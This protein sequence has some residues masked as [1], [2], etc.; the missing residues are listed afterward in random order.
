MSSDAD[1]PRPP[2]ARDAR[3]QRLEQQLRANLR[4]RKDAARGRDDAGRSPTG[5][6]GDGGEG[7]CGTEDRSD[8][9]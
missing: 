8:P 4:R 5:A 6:I 2:P 3:Q 1:R 7:G 9:A